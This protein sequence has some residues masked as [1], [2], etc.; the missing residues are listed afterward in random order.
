V[1]AELDAAK[2]RLRRVLAERRRVVEGDERSAAGEAIREHLVADPLVGSARHIGLFA[3]LADEPPTRPLFDALERAGRLCLLPRCRAQQLVY[4]PVARWEDLRP[5]RYGVLEPRRGEPIAEFGADDVVLV[6]G[7]AFDRA[8]HRLGRGGGYYDR[9]FPPGR[10]GGPLLFGLC[11]A[12]QVVDDVPHDSRD[13]RMDAIVTERGLCRI[14]ET[15][16]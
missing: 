9:T 12:L 3:A 1:P 6:P 8:G 15:S 11:Y 14:S 7:L 10:S 5:G 16:A 2:R 4:A 13:C